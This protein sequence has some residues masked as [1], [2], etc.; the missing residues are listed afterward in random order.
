MRDGEPQR[1]AGREVVRGDL[2]LLAEGDR[3]P[4]DAVLV[5]A[6]GAAG[7]RIAAHRRGG[8]GG[9]AGGGAP[10]S[11]RPR[12]SRPTPPRAPGGDDLPF[13]LLRHA[14]RA[15]PG[16]ARVTATGARSE[17]GRIGTALGTLETER[18]PLQKQTARLVRKLALLALALSLALVLVHGLLRG[19]WLRRCWPASRWRWRCCPRS[20][21]WC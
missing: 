12:R 21:R 13:G 6:D 14:G 10:M 20:S 17:I 3:V 2:L 7:G 11:W 8:A 4:A 5:S 9:Q 19:D 1:I 16:M 15:G 18:S